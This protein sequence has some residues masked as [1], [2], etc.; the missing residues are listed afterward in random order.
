MNQDTFLYTLPQWFIFLAIIIITYGWVEQKKPF[1]IIGLVIFILLGLFAVYAVVEG[2][3]SG[4]EFLTPNEI[5]SEEL[6]EELIEEIPFQTQLLPAY[7]SFMVS[8]VLAIPA[9]YFDWK[10]KKPT[11][12]FIVLAGLVSLFGFFIIVGALRML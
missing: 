12:L 1:R 3:F 6:E 11:H 7:W 8:A 9:I 10:N 4:N 2:Y 5:I